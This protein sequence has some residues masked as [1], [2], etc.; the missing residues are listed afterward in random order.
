MVIPRD[1]TSF[2]ALS[3]L[4]S[5][6]DTE[7]FLRINSDDSKWIRRQ[8]NASGPVNDI[9]LCG[10]NC[11][12]TTPPHDY[13]LKSIRTAL[14]RT[15]FRG[16]GTATNDADE[17]T[18]GFIGSDDGKHWDPFQF[19]PVLTSDTSIESATFAQL[20]GRY[21]IYARTGR[22]IPK[23]IMAVSRRGQPSILPSP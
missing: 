19:N 9:L 21:F 7:V 14:G 4:N 6:L 16:L 20:P 10:S 15:L 18:L 12:S 13:E 8:V 23:I 3:V 1:S 17:S 5:G 22:R 2:S 11:W